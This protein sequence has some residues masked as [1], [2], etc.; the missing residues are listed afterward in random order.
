MSAIVMG[1]LIMS[2]VEALIG[3]KP[4]SWIWTVLALIAVAAWSFEILSP[5]PHR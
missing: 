5:H 4:L 2:R 3:K 1:C